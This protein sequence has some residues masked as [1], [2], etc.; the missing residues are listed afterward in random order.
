M[1]YELI[2]TKEDYDSLNEYFTYDVERVAFLLA[3]INETQNKTA[4]LINQIYYLSSTEYL[5]QR[6]DQFV[7]DSAAFRNVF[8]AARKNRM[9]IIMAH[10][11]PGSVLSFP[12][13]FSYADLQGELKMQIDFSRLESQ[14]HAAIVFGNSGSVD[15]RVWVDGINHPVN[16]IKVL[17]R[18]MRMIKPTSS[19]D[20]SQNDI[21]EVFDRQILAFGSAGQA[22]LR[23]INVAVVGA[24]GTGSFVT[25]ELAHLGVKAITLLDND[26]VEFSNL[27]RLIGATYKD[28]E[29]KN[30]K[31]HV[32][33]RYVEQLKTGAVLDAHLE[34][35]DSLNGINIVRSADVIFCCTDNMTSRLF[36]NQIAHQYYIPVL[37][38]GVGMDSDQGMLTGGGGYTKVILPNGICL[39]C[40]ED[41][42]PSLLAFERMPAEQRESAILSGYIRNIKSPSVISLNGLIS[43]M[44]ITDF[45]NLMFGFE[46][47]DLM[48]YKRYNILTG[49][50]K[51]VSA[52]KKDNCY[53]RTVKGQGHKIEL[54]QI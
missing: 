36:L 27:N 22:L 8:N 32:F 12:A 26:I 34:K 52:G 10:N 50:V 42:N 21:P 29:E 33:K 11:H 35:L 6:S 46:Q 25:M 30:N 49:N 41:I 2:F 40:N 18:P 7:L 23:N 31:V 19:P 43:S 24:G 39:Q 13:R 37:D 53:C 45:L 28:A 38:M 51:T 3:G 20:L 44:A 17:G 16:I 4:M 54:W 14:P 15:A 9:S 5:V 1:N 48:D 47:C